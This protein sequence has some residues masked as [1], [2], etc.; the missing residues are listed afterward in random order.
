MAKKPKKQLKEM[1]QEDLKEL[2]LWLKK[3][4]K[5]LPDVVKNMVAH[6]KFL[7][8]GL[9]ADNQQWRT[10]FIELRRAL[11]IIPKSEKRKNSGDPHGRMSQ[12]GAPKPKNKKE[13]LLLSRQ[14]SLDLSK[15]H[16][17][18]AKKHKLKAKNIDKTLMKLE[19][20]Q[21]SP[22]ELAQSERQNAAFKDRINLGVGNGP[23]P[24]LEPP[25]QAFM[26][27]ADIVVVEETV[28]ASVD[29][30]RLLGQEVVSR[31][32]DE[33]TRYG[34]S[35][36]LNQVNIEVE[37]V[38]VKDTESG[39][40]ILSASTRDIGPPK[41]DVTWEF[42]SNLTI[43]VSQYAMPFNRLGNML[44]VPDKRFSSGMLA[45]MFCYVAERL[46]PVY[47]H[48]FEK[49]ADASL[50]SG[51]DTS[52]RVIE[53]KRY[54]E[55]LTNN[56]KSIGQAPWINYAT[57]DIAKETKNKELRP[58]LGVLTAEKLGFE[59]NR[60]D[61]NGQKKS[62]QTSLIWGRSEADNPRSAI[63]FY[64]SHLGG[65]GNLLSKCI[66]S[67]DSKNHDLIVQSDL[68][69]INLIS[70]AK[71]N[72]Q[73]N[74]QQAGCVSHARRPF[75]LYE[76]EDPN[77][78]QY[79]LHLF[80]GLYIHEKCLDL[81]DRNWANVAAVRGIDSQLLWED[82]KE[83][84]QTMTQKWS[85]GTKLGA[86]ARYIIRHYDKL[87][88]YLK[89]PVI[90]LS[91]DFSERMLRME[92]LIQN[93]ALFRNTLEGRF[94]LDINRSILQTAIAARAPL[95][96]YINYVLRA[97]PDEVMANPSLFTALKYTSESA[98]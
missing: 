63:I 12:P 4:A 9:G 59:F 11:G 52:P 80:K 93:N 2:D 13:R 79:M 47:L 40:K 46:L 14:Q 91:N 41:M 67:R 85:K 10:M 24:A 60:K 17:E 56:P 51:D 61:G 37:K 38:V 16:Q 32:I 65:F 23:D 98:E 28:T 49:L 74:I 75:A 62:L 1:G 57:T 30:A 96:E 3:N 27:G 89:N 8:Q 86:A 54:Y 50:L 25:K 97:H 78:C 15:W 66:E 68:S 95:Q 33:R 18:M 69:S 64:R 42:L 90:Y 45:R 21:L 36:S 34:F 87:T 6:Y 19:D 20:I 7:L 82:I 73:F 70:D 72:E 35:L 76:D 55:F 5:Q 94:A 88:L 71:F 29:P 48:N 58:G 31:M 77:N 26:E 39:T 22:E 83:L 92:N 53:V 44:S 81:H 84:A 43:M